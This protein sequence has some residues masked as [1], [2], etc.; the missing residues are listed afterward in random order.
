MNLEEQVR[1]S[2]ASMQTALLSAHPDLPSLLRKIHT[3]LKANPDIVTLLS[4]DEIGIIV[5]GLSRQ[6][7][8]TIASSISKGGKGKT[9]KSL[10][11]DDL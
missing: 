3:T 11:V 9:I 7:N 4:E 2:I 8:I 6:Q 1:E 10:T 5:N